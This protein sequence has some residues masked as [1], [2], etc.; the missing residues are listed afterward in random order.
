MIKKMEMPQEAMADEIALEVDSSDIGD[1]GEA[2]QREEEKIM[3]EIMP[4]EAHETEEEEAKKEIIEEA[5]SE[6]SQ[7]D[8]GV[9]DEL[10]E[11]K[12]EIKTL[13]G[14]AVGL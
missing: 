6:L 11:A 9:I 8:E 5:V 4:S 12:A 14:F 13:S 2:L 3:K 10:L 1:S 7:E